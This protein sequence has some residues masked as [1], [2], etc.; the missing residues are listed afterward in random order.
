[1]AGD[2]LMCC[3]D[4]ALFLPTLGKDELPIGFQHGKAPNFLQIA[5]EVTLSYRQGNV[6]PCHDSLLLSSPAQVKPVQSLIEDTLE[7]LSSKD[8]WSSGKEERYSRHLPDRGW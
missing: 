8:R 7:S 3:I 4:V 1:M 5:T 2:Q 6:C